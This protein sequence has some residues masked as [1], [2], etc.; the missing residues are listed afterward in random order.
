[1]NETNKRNIILKQQ[2]ICFVFYFH[3]A[4]TNHSLHNKNQKIIVVFIYFT[5]QGMGKFVFGDGYKCVSI[6]KNINT[7]TNETFF[8]KHKCKSFKRLCIK[9]HNDYVNSIKYGS[10]ELLNTILSGSSDKSIRFWDIR[11]NKKELYVIKGIDKNDEITCLTFSQSKERK[12]NCC[13]AEINDKFHF[14]TLFKKANIK[15]ELV[16]YVMFFSGSYNET[17]RIWDIETII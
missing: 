12:E 14:N 8:G 15:L 11:S 10:N 17:I 13:N 1:L 6:T 2:L 7:N 3:F 9:R 16:N 4:Q 5:V